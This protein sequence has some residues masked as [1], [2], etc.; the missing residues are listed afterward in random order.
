MRDPTIAEI[1]AL[2]LQLLDN[3]WNIVPSSPR[4][5]T[6]YVVGW[7]TIAANEFYLDKWAWSHSAH[8]NT[9]VVANR[10][11][12]GVDIDV[13]SDPDLAHRVQALA[14]EYLGITPFIRVGQWPKRLLVYR[15][16]RDRF[17]A[18]DRGKR[19]RLSSSAVRS[20]A[21][22]AANGSGDGI[23]ILSSGKQFVIDGFHY[24]AGQPYR[25]VGEASPLEDRPRD[26]PL[27]TQ[28]QV[29]AFLAAVEKIMPLTS[30][31]S[32]RGGNGGNA[33]RHV[34]TAGLVDD[35]RESCLRDCIWAAAHEIE[36]EG[37]A[38]TAA[39]V[40]DWGWKLFEERAWNGDGKY[41]RDK[42]AMEKARGLIRRLG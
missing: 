11:Y 30:A 1:L 7:P 28:E 31:T 5:K 35:G 39:A 23:E 17:E 9:A 15:K 25:W 27:T 26:A 3:D 24:K 37:D 42:Q 6:C 20:V 38:L 32:R 29:D 22:K 19:V 33:A 16:R 14:F 40:A 34:N 10:N 4:D 21:F 8:S 2:R 12:F 36:E 13:L 18:Y 41:S